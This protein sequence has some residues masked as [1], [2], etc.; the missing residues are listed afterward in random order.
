MNNNR[1]KP[2]STTL[3]GSMP[4]SKELLDLKEKSIKDDK[5]A[6]E[7]KEKVYSETEKIIQMS[8]EIGIDVVVSGELARDKLYCSTRSWSKAHDNGRYKEN[9]R[10]YGRIQ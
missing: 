1:F 10:K 9:Y 4:R 6:E 8:E 5:Y 2:F 3:M 7:Y